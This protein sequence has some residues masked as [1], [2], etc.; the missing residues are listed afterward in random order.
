MRFL[1]LLGWLIPFGIF[2]QS[3]AITGTVTD[4]DD[5]IALP[6]VSVVEKGTYNGTVTDLDGNYTIMVSSNEATLMFT[7]IGYKTTDVAIAGNSNVD[8]ALSA[9]IAGLE[10]AI[11]IG[12]GN[13]QR[14]K[15]S[16]AVGTIDI[17]D[18]TSVP[19]LRTEQALQGRAAGVQVTQNSG[20]PGSTQSIRIRGTGS[21]NNA[22]P[23]WVVDGIPS[24]GIDYLNP[25]D[26]ES[27]SVL[28]DAASAAIYGA[29]GGN[30]VILVTTK[31]GA[32]G[33]PAQVTYDTYYGF[34]EPWKKIGLLNAEQ[35]AILMNESRAAAGLVPLAQLS[36]PASLGEGTD[37]QDA[38]FQ[39][40]PMVNHSFNFTKG[41]ATSSTAIGG[42]HFAQ[43]GIIGGEKG[44]FERTTFRV[45][46][47]QDAGD[48]FRIGQ[49]VNF[50]HI[51]R[52]ALAE[53]N[54][55][56]TPV[57]RALNMDP[58]TPVSRPDGSYAYSELIGS[59]IANPINQVETTFDNWVTNR[60]VGN[61]YGEYDLLKEL[62][63]RSSVNIDLSLGSQKIFLPQYD[64]GIGENDPN[65]PAYEWREVNGLIRNENKWSNWQWENT[66]QYD[67]ELKNGD[68]IQTILGYSALYGNY[69]NI[70]TY[71]D[72]LN[73]NDPELAFLD[74]SLNFNEQAPN[75][76][77]GFGES[78]Y[79]STFARVQYELGD[80]YSMSGTVRR[81]GS[82]KFGANNRYGIFPSLS[83][84]WNLTEIPWVVEKD[85]IEF[86]KVRASWGRNG[87][88][89]GIG[90]FDFTSVV[91]NGQNY[92]F[93][94]DQQQVNG[95][96]PV[97]T[98]N[99]DLKW[100][101]VDQ[102]N[103]GVD[104][105]LYRGRFNIVLDYFVKNTNDML[106]VVPVPGVVGFLPAAT[107]VASARNKGI[108][109]ALTYR[110]EKGDW[111]YDVTGNLSVIR[112]EITGLGEGGQ[113]IN[114]GSVFGAGNDFTAYTDIGL[115][116]A[117]FYGYETAGIFQTDEEAI[118]NT[119]QPEAQAGDVIFVDQNEDGV[120]DE[121]DKTVIGN[122]HP[123]F[124]FGLT[125]NVKWKNFD[126]S[127]FIQGSQ[128]NDLFNGIFRYDLN[129]TNLPV[130][131]LERWTGEGSTN[132]H[133]RIT[134]TDA[135]QN[136]RVSDRFI[137]DGSFVRIKNLQIGY[138]LPQ[139]IQDKLDIGKCR[140]YVSASNL[141]TLTNYSGLD[142]EIGSRG[143]LEIGIDRGFYPVGRNF[144]AGINVTF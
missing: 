13:Q 10:E 31:K 105:D 89:D 4:A 62:K 72:S 128:G 92:T 136:N 104:L 95:A 102:F 28:K 125:G 126:A 40:A 1:L 144:I 115:P 119:A 107:N 134:H 19:V 129:T 114:T 88:A 6:G 85:W 121:N 55:F 37:W 65:R 25:A 75:A 36:D 66:L 34:Q 8:H 113:P 135:N 12:Y 108:E 79:L 56:A 80:R 83:A 32:K 3:T 23:L 21:L 142:P 70:G 11:V 29:R 60:F 43:D 123:D 97:T 130:S 35:Y 48:R 103:A 41:T 68:R 20:Q 76:S 139:S 117:V 137:E 132:E 86:A 16:G 50:T 112:N 45:S 78:S 24:G 2:A 47:Q 133:P 42:S 81:D 58:V 96:G 30:G 39:R 94:P 51:S 90:N 33:Q 26:I 9:D 52:N 64:L 101:T 143:T 38:L 141:L 69:Q 77:G 91:F 15:I 49:T 53:N 140:F 120:L 14:S 122:P 110:G 59:D 71:R 57:V 61:M 18:A 22:E 124:T 84:A 82:S 118:A 74:N 99:P 111:E 44:R 46:T 93:G 98:S 5:G 87:N 17:K 116:M 67:K 73:S 106:A 54:E 27:I 100:E 7:Y 63:F 131:A 127:I 138:T 109:L